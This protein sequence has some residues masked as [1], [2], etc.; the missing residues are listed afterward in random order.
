MKKTILF[1]LL[2]GASVVAV[3]DQSTEVNSSLYPSPV[4]S[5]Y[6]TT[7]SPETV[8][9]G[10]NVVHSAFA[11][12]DGTS[13]GEV[14]GGPALDT[15]YSSWSKVQVSGATNILAF[16][17][18][19]TVFSPDMNNVEGVAQAIVEYA[20]K[21]NFDGI[22]F[23]LENVKGAAANSQLLK[24]IPAIRNIDP[25]L[26]I[27]AAPQAYNGLSWASTSGVDT[28][29]PLLKDGACGTKDCL[30]AVFVQNYNNSNQNNVQYG[31]D[32]VV[33]A[34]SQANNPN[35]TTKF[36]IGF[37]Q[38]VNPSD[39]VK[40]SSTSKYLTNFAGLGLWPTSQ[41]EDTATEQVMVKVMGL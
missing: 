20:T 2:L 39:I 30:D 25:S 40:P 37:E 11:G 16:G 31:W 41:A 1:T 22:D 17:G 10:V 32:Q 35:L 13:I 7:W 29:V 14:I 6:N 24:I 3:A 19:T 15:E 21:Y 18:Q 12:I 23:D 34:I 8:A 33:T 26:I 38:T 9:Q 36:I 27:M 28:I 4:V 5:I